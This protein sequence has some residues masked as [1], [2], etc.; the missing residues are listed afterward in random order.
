MR[1]ADIKPRMNNSGKLEK[2]LKFQNIDFLKD[3]SKLKNFWDIAKED[4][5]SETR[6]AEFYETMAYHNIGITKN[7]YLSILRSALYGT[8]FSRMNN[9]SDMI[10]EIAEFSVVDK[11]FQQI[12]NYNFDDLLDY[13]ISKLRIK[14]DIKS[15]ME[16]PE[17]LIKHCHGFLPMYE[18]WRQYS[19][20]NVIL[21][22]DAYMELLTNSS[23]EA[24][25]VQ[26]QLLQ[27]TQAWLVG[28]S[29]NDVNLR[30]L[31]WQS[32]QNR[33]KNGIKQRHIAFIKRIRLE[34]GQIPNGRLRRF[35]NFELFHD[36]I[37][38]LNELGVQVFTVESFDELPLKFRKA[39]NRSISL[40]TE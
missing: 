1:Y 8:N 35:L 26:S 17:D 16:I 21:S 13:K 30:R 34:E 39:L 27:N 6:R 38:I 28:F 7:E 4:F 2:Y 25:V 29:F 3:Q 36:Q 18:S 5:S 22:D 11:V 37:K 19:S 15:K 9:R 23:N 32:K 12:I 10:D 33:N 40:K 20:Q 24:N 14:Y 31:L